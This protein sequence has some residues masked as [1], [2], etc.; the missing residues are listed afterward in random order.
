LC[1]CGEQISAQISHTYS[2]RTLAG[3]YEANTKRIRSEYEANTKRIRSEY[4]RR[5]TLGG[6]SKEVKPIVKQT[7]STWVV[8]PYSKI[9][10]NVCEDFKAKKGV[11]PTVS[12]KKLAEVAR[13]GTFSG[14][15]IPSHTLK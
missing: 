15:V 14:K 4:E 1:C 10:I 9:S 2:R 3:E 8:K 7:G 11:F 5:R 13:S 12:T 6:G